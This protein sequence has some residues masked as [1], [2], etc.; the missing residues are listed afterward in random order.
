MLHLI[1]VS[2]DCNDEI[3]MVMMVMIHDG[4]DGNDGNDG[5]GYIMIDDC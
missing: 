1:V 2:H 5:N 4:S 3:M